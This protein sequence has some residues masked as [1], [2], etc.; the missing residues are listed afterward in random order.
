MFMHSSDVDVKCLTALCVQ[1]KLWVHARQLKEY[2][3][4]RISRCWDLALPAIK[5]DFLWIS[6]CCLLL[7][8]KLFSNLSLLEGL[9]T[10]HSRLFLFSAF[11]GF[12]ETKNKKVTDETN[13]SRKGKIWEEKKCNWR[14]FI[15]SVACFAG[16]HS[17]LKSRKKSTTR[18]STIDK[19]IGHQ[20]TA[21]DFAGISSRSWISWDEHER[22]L[23]SKK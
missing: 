11:I 1:T 15:S 8:S 21:K 22:P 10:Q 17:I 2:N 12:L 5:K 13:G 23:I 19:I 9:F 6:H 3:A 16:E 7:G 4:R 20:W 14:N 18:S